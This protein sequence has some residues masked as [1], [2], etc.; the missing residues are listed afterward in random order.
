[1]NTMRQRLLLV[2]GWVIVASVTSLVALGAVT[3][4]GGRVNDR[5]LNPLSAAEVAALPV[6]A[7][8]QSVN[9]PQASGGDDSTD[10]TSTGAPDQTDRTREG[11]AAADAGGELEPD[12]VSGNDSAPTVANETK[13]IRLEGGSVSVRQLASDLFLQWATPQ[14]G[15]STEVILTQSDFVRVMFDSATH[16]SLLLV[17]VDDDGIETTVTESENP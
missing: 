9:E 3:V 13:V 12:I 4:A 10:D 8:V 5:P 6:A 2:V 17:T 7:T 14:P 15:Y 11:D 16:R 1:M